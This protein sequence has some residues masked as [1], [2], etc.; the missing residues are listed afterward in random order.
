MPLSR[1]PSPPYYAVI[2][3]SVRTDEDD[4]GYGIT[5]TE[6][7]HLAAEQEGYLGQDSTARDGEG[8]GITVSYWR[9]EASI[10]AW[11]KQLDHTA[12]RNMGREKWYKSYTLRVARVERA[13]DFDRPEQA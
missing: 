6:M 5:A 7:S 3:A 11:K 9:D 4:E 1:L 10:H 13:Y 12:A 8:M 2:F